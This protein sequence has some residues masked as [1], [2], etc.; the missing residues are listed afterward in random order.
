MATGELE[1]T[2]EGRSG[3]HGSTS[4]TREKRQE[5]K[6]EG[7]GKKRSGAQQRGHQRASE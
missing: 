1:G 7:E 2:S 5:R 4:S 6:I 3:H